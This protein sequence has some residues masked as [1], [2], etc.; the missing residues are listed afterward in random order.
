MPRQTAR[1]S[2]T[3]YARGGSNSTGRT[4]NTD[5]TSNSAGRSNSAGYGSHSTASSSSTPIDGRRAPRRN[6]REVPHLDEL[7]APSPTTS[8]PSMEG[9]VHERDYYYT[10]WRQSIS[11]VREL[12]QVIGTQRRHRLNL[13]ERLNALESEVARLREGAGQTFEPELISLS[14]DEAGSNQ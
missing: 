11:T 2:T 12:R 8:S 6:G 13:L 10:L 3:G 4:S 14:D 7:E 5:R 9:V 1:K